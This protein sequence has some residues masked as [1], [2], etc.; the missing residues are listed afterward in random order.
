MPLTL[1]LLAAAQPA[2]STAGPA[3]TQLLTG[4]WAGGGEVGTGYKIEASATYR[5]DRTFVSRSKIAAPGQPVQDTSINGRWEAKEGK[6]AGTCTIA[7]S[8]ESGAGKSSASSDVLIVDRD[9][10][11]FW[12]VNMRRVK[13]R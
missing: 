13:A 9:T 2:I 4:S 10:Y 8:T 12:G 11:Q 1:L 6:R 7:M 3:C 5:A